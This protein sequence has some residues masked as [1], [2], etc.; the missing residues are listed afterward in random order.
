MFTLNLKDTN[1]CVNCRRFLKKPHTLCKLCDANTRVCISCN[2][3]FKCQGDY[4][5]FVTKCSP[6]YNGGKFYSYDPF[7]KHKLK[8]DGY[9]PYA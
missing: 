1:E 4:R 2:R 3:R 5:D 9:N 6:C 8:A 7:R